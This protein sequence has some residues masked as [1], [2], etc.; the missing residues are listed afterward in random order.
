MPQLRYT[1]PHGITVMRTDSKVPYGRGLDALLK[2]LDTRRG[3]YLSSGYEYPE[4]YSRWD[5][6]SIAPPVEIIGRGRGL[7]IHALN[8]RGRVLVQL[9]QKFLAS[10]PD[11]E[12]FEAK[13]DTLR[14]QLRPLS[15]VFAEEER[16]KQPSPFSILRAFVNEFHNPADSRLVLA[17][18]FGYDLLLQHKLV[19]AGAGLLNAAEKFRR[20]GV[21]RRLERLPQHDFIIVSDPHA[22]PHLLH[23]GHVLFG[24]VI[25]NDFGRC[26]RMLVGGNSGIRARHWTAV[27]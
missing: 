13:E 8:Q 5:V 3:I 10:H 26:V 4:R 14:G 6:A 17:G 22:L 7:D 19:R 27:D 18:A 16:S 15:G 21:E 11:W 25:G 24:L 9:F 23:L 1:T 12:S 2:Q 20:A